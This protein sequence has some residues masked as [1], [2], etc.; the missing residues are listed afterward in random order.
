MTLD[1]RL[2]NKE[3]SGT[4]SIRPVILASFIGTTIEWY[5]FFLYGTAAAL[6]FNKLF[7]PNVT[8]L[9]GTLSAFGTFAVGFVARPV[10]GV[11]FGH[12][13]DRIGRKSMLIYSLLIMGIATFI[14]GLLPTYASIGILAPILLVA[15]RFAQGIGVGGEWGGAVLMAV[16]HS[17]QGS[18]GFHGSWVQMGVGAG[19]LLSTITFTLFSSSLSQAEFLAWGWRV[20]FLLSFVL[21]G[22]GLFIRLRIFETP[23][24]A[25]L[26][27]TQGETRRPIVEV[28]RHQPRE[29]LLAMGMRFAENGPFYIMSVFV[30]SY[31]ET[32]LKLPKSTMLTGVIIA[33]TISLLVIPVYGALSDRIGR[34]PVYQAGA[35]FTFLFAF[36]FFWLLE[37]RSPSLIWLAIALAVN[38]GHDPMYA[39][40]AAYF[41]ELFG[42]RVRYTGA[43]LVYQLSSVFAGGLAPLIATGLLAWIGSSAVASYVAVMALITILSTYLATET[44]RDEISN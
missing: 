44:F 2:D 18:R 34:R 33:S 12:F 23:I 42:T 28:L 41:S 31:G 10:G 29:V 35:L 24:F 37:T 4:A 3:K 7:F 32:H 11:I 20:P 43:S 13:G 1:P 16:E 14:I 17:T 6:V 5:D 22:V 25:R 27:E 39:V 19:L 21:V 26:K 38:V 36:P 30:L 8:P 9:A 15:M 40:Q